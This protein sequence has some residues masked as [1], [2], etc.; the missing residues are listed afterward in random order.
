METFNPDNLASG[1]K[2]LL[3]DADYRRSIEKNVNDYLENKEKLATDPDSMVALGKLG[4]LI[5]SNNYYRGKYAE[6]FRKEFESAEQ[7]ESGFFTIEKS[8]KIL[9]DIIG[10][11]AFR[12]DIAK[13]KVSVLLKELKQKSVREWTRQL[14]ILSLKGRGTEILGPKGRD[15]YLRDMGYL[16]RVPVDIHEMRF[17]IR[18]GIYHHCSRNLFDPLKKGDLQNA[19]VIFCKDHLRGLS[20]HDLDLS[21]NP[22]IADLI[23]WHHCADPPGLGICAAKPKCLEKKTICP[24]SEACLFSTMRNNGSS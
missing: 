11:V 24:L 5:A 10:K 4:E 16:D 17:I 14:Y 23:I 7:L 3:E 12:P 1:F 15:I 19:L 21:K 9:K 20:V 8:K 6:L 22:G 2:H 18:T 13:K